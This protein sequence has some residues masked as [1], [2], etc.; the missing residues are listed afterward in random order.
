M[1]EDMGDD[2]TKASETNSKTYNQSV[3][4]EANIYE[5]TTSEAKTIN[6]MEIHPLINV[7]QNYIKN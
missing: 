6:K 4:E 3:T 7:I 5:A 1:I 2:L